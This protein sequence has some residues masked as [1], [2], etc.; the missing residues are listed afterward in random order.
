[1]DSALAAVNAFAAAHPFYFAAATG[2]GGFFARSF[3]FT[4]ENARRLIKLWFDK[5]RAA[6][7]KAGSS[8]AEIQSVMKDEAD[9]LLSA[10][11][12]AQAEAAG[13]AAPK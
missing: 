10:A 11:Q 8:D 12:E 3:I 1:M 2:L 7:K 6:L 5:Q 4:K 9:F 13:V